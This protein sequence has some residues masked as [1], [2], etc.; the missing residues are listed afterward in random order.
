MYKRAGSLNRGGSSAARIPVA[1]RHSVSAKTYIAD[2]R[3]AWSLRRLPREGAEVS[4]PALMAQR[5]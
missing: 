5:D 4:L 3:Y 2:R 1:S